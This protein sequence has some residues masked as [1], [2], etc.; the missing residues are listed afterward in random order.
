MRR[1]RH[2]VAGCRPGGGEHGAYV[3]RADERAVLDRRGHG[4]WDVEDLVTLAGGFLGRDVGRKA[5][6]GRT[7]KGGLCEPGEEV[8]GTGSK[9]AH[10]DAGPAG[11]LALGVG[12]VGGG[13]LVMGQ[14][15][16]NPVALE[17]IEHGEHFAAGNAVGTADAFLGQE[18]GD[19]VGDG[20]VRHGE[21]VE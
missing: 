21:C 17:G 20:Y 1:S 15:E 11:E 5:E 10:A 6:D 2:A 7:L 3:L 18:A 8:G 9:S 4:S 19:G 12:H 16:F 14:D 13:R